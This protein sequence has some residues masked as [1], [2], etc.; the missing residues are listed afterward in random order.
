M[1]KL[2]VACFCVLIFACG[3]RKKVP[4]VSDI[5]INLS[6]QRFDQDFFS[7]DTNNIAASLDQLQKKYPAFLNDFLFNI[8]GLPPKPDSLQQKVKLFIR[9]YRS[10]YD[11]VQQHFPNISQQ[12]KELRYAL[13]LAKYYFPNYTASQE[14]ITFVGPLEGYGNVLTNSGYA[15]G[16]QLYLGKDFSLYKTS[17]VQEVYPT[18]QSRRFE[19]Q[20]IVTNCMKNILSDLYPL[21]NKVKPLVEQMVEQGRRLYVLDYLLPETA[22]SVK[23][24]YTQTQLDGCYEHEGII[25]NFFIENDLLYVSDPFVIRDYVNDG[26]KTAVLGEASPGNIAQFVGWQIVKKWMKEHPEKTLQQLMETPLKSIFQEAKYK[27][28]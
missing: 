17:W 19:P 16:L 27:P 2:A 8:L 5:K 4:D 10:V 22:D 24:G 14:L 13:Q 15:I 20:Y 7:I 28:R 6:V 12:E 11:S 26:P 1:K 21:D 18:Y 25:W 9:D 3:N 23:M